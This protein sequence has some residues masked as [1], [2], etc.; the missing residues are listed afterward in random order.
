[1][2]SQYRFSTSL[3]YAGTWR[4]RATSDDVGH[5]AS[6]SPYENLRIH[7]HLGGRAVA[8]SRFRWRRPS[9]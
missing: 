8:S 3:P 9:A 2:V 5:R 7:Q 6:Y 1:M 4:I